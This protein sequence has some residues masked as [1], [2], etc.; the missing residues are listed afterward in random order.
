MIGKNYEWKIV[1]ELKPGQN[2][3]IAQAWQKH[4]KD[5][6]VVSLGRKEVAEIMQADWDKMMD[7]CMSETFITT[8]D[9][10]TSTTKSEQPMMQEIFTTS[11]RVTKEA[12]RRG[13][14]VAPPL[15]WETGWDFR[16]ALDRRAALKMVDEKKPYFLIIAYPCGPWSP[17]MRLN[18]AADLAEKQEEARQ[19]IRF[20]LQLARLQLRNGRHFALENP[21]GS[22]S[23]QL[24]E[25]IKF[26]EEEEARIAR[27]DQCRFGLR[28]EQ[29]KLHKKGTQIVTSSKAMQSN[30]H[31]VRCLRDHEH[32][33]VIG[34]SK[35][36][37][38]AGHY[39]QGLARTLVD[40][41]E[42]EFHNQYKAK[43][44]YDILAAEHDGE[45]EGGSGDEAS[46]HEIPGESS[47]EEIAVDEGEKSLKVSPATRQ[48]IR[49]LH[50][51]TGHRSNK[52]L[53]RAL[54][55]AGAPAEVIKAARTLKCSICDEK[56]PPKARRPASL[57]TPKDVSDQV[58]VDMLELNDLNDQR[59]YVIHCIDHA[60]RFQLAEALPNKST[61]AVINFLKTR[62]FPI[63]GPP[64]VMVADQG[65]EFV[66]WQFEELCAQNSILLWHC[67]VQAPWQNGVCERG[68]GVLKAIAT[69]VIR[70]QSVVGMED[71]QLA[72]QEAVTAYNHDVNDAGVS[73][74]QAA[75]G[76]QPRLQGDVLGDFGQRLAEH[77]LVDSKPGL[78]R[79]IAMR[80]VARVA[81]ARLHF[82]RSLRKALLSRSRSTTITQPLEPGMIVYYFRN[83][84]YNSRTGPS[85]KKLSLKRWHGPALLV[86]NE[87]D[88]NCYL[89]HKGQLTKCAREHVRPASTM[90]QV[91][92]EVWKDSI[93]DVVDAAMH[94]LTVR[95][96]LS[97]TTP[98]SGQALPL[99]FQADVP[100]TVSAD[101]SPIEDETPTIQ[102]PQQQL[103]SQQQPQLQAN[104]AIQPPNQ[105]LNLEEQLFR[106]L[107]PVTSQEFARAIT[108]HGGSTGGGSTPR[109]LASSMPPSG[110]SSRRTSISSV[111]RQPRISARME[112]IV[113]KARDGG[114]EGGS[115]KRVAEVS[116]DDLAASSSTSGPSAPKPPMDALILSREE[117]LQVDR[118]DLHPLRRLWLETV[119]EHENPLDHVVED[120]GTWKGYWPLQAV[121]SVGGMWPRG[122]QEALAVQTARKEYRWK[123]LDEN[124]RACFREATASGWSVWLD[125]RAV[126]VLSPGEAQ[127]VRARLKSTGQSNLI[128]TPRFVLTDKHDGLRTQSCP[129]PLKASARLVVP[130]YKDSSCYSVRKDAPTGSRLSVHLLLTYT[131]AN[132]W[133]LMSADVKSAFLK[134]EEFGPNERELYIEN[135]KTT[136]P[137]EPKLPLGEGGLARL[138]KGIFGLSDSPRRW[139]LRLH[140]SLTALG[141]IR[142]AVDAAMWFLWSPDHKTLEAMVISHVD[143]LLFGGNDRGRGLLLELGKELGMDRWKRNSLSTAANSL[144]SMKMEPFR[145]R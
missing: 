4:E 137:D 53:A 12:Q 94:D 143:D 39:P 55:I 111:G 13:H 63:F 31:D 26:L 37:S 57:P 80:E 48:A 62:W 109:S 127:K 121:L 28:S 52:R 123:E 104:L 134:G 130:G 101:P 119:E 92:A 84:K 11:Q 124:A 114:S 110:L 75:L 81:M 22:S 8:I 7:Q 99:E 89:S 14:V 24:P 10:A 47:D 129:L 72:V 77:G 140:R 126:D 61:D 87:G 60:S 97:N 6:Q 32:Q 64:R 141:F 25:V 17:L 58:H 74:A 18:P 1:Q 102:R 20:A 86:A 29:G 54:T 128:L 67:A 42:A 83:T 100:P 98:A 106:D 2:Q 135:V 49:R 71:M 125:N 69:A 46:V 21:I 36:T 56:R 131:A 145:F 27:F 120:R 9:L 144:S 93:Q 38:R 136:H 16:K 33:Q 133:R 103:Q 117:M 105:Q 88:T 44:N 73:P 78:A 79:Q 90:E 108:G 142:S 41:M 3:M 91:S 65:R 116:V 23:W 5:R 15:S 85:K 59:Y 50:E 35:I 95:G 51:N 40:S 112:S 45:A 122:E 82:S 66:S 113:E 19:L 138:R 139:Y 68:G 107:P 96:T 76:K 34:G 115:V 118:D 43:E 70:S 30:L 132:K